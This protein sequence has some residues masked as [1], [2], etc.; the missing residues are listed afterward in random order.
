MS[1]FVMI[2]DCILVDPERVDAVAWSDY[3]QRT[4]IYV[5]GNY[6]EVAKPAQE[7]MKILG[8]G[9]DLPVEQAVK[10]AVRRK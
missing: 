10:K 9:I 6:V 3:T 1:R 4:T 2:N 5:N 7:V 8:K